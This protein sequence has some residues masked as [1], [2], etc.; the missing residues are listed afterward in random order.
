MAKKKKMIEKDLDEEDDIQYTDEEFYNKIMNQ[1]IDKE[2]SDIF[3]SL[4]NSSEVHSESFES[5]S[6]D[7]INQLVENAKDDRDLKK[8]YAFWLLFA[9]WAQL[10]IFN[11]F[12]MGAGI[13]VYNFDSSTLNLYVTGGIIEIIALIKIIISYLFQDNLTESLKSILDK[14]DKKNKEE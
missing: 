8:Q 4:D 6:L 7:F 11:L 9:F 14:I 2:L 13:N 12:F 1:Q 3:N 5:V 10:I